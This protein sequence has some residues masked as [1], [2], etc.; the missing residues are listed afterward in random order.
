MSILAI[1][2]EGKVPLIRG[3]L[4]AKTPKELR[5]EWR[6]YRCHTKKN[7]MWALRKYASSDPNIGDFRPMYASG[8][9]DPRVLDAV[10]QIG[11][12]SDCLGKALWSIPDDVVGEPLA[13]LL[14]DTAKLLVRAGDS[15]MTTEPELQLWVKHLKPVRRRY[16]LLVKQ[17][18][19]ACYQEASELGVLNGNQSVD[20]IVRFL[21]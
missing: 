5:D 21:L 16:M 19:I 2:E 20:D 3:L 9:D 12:Y 14:F 6:A 18:L 7:V 4:T 10:K 15:P 11:F 13:R 1:E 17:A 8:N